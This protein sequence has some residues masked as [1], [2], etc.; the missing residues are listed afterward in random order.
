MATI[1]AAQ[2]SFEKRGRW[3]LNNAHNVIVQMLTA[4]IVT[5]W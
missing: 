4:A 3:V 2:G 1:T 5:L